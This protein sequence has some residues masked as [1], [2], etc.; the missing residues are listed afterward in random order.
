MPSEGM[1]LI[2]RK[3]RHRPGAQLRITN[4]EGLRLTRFAI[5]T[6]VVPIAALELRHRQ[7]ARAEDGIRPAQPALAT[8]CRTGSGWRSSSSSWTYW[9]GWRCLP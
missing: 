6:A 8:P 2:V 5:N 9:P 3:E 4:A 1:R 7:R